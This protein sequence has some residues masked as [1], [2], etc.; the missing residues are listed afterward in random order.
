ME[1]QSR[2]DNL[3]LDGVPET[4]NESFETCRNK[5]V[6]ILE[7]NMQ[8]QNAR[9][10]KFVRCHRLGPKRDFSK[11][12][13]T[14]IFKF[15]YF[16]D[17]EQV[18]SSKTKLKNSDYWL[19]EDFPAE[20]KKR[21]SVLYPVLKKAWQLHLKAS[22]SVDKLII[23]GRT[24]TVDNLSS[25]PQE[26]DPAHIATRKVGNITCFFSSSS[27][28]SNFHNTTIKDADGKKFHTSE[29]FYQYHKAIHFNDEESAYKILLAD[30]PLECY[31]L[32]RTIKNFNKDVWHNGQAKQVMHK[33]VSAKFQ[34]NQKLCDFLLQTND[35][36]LVEANPRDRDWGVGLSVH[37]KDIGNETMWRG[38]NWLGEILMKVRGELKESQ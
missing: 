20:I 30:T 18:W 24:Y 16:Q 6:K 8:I 12:P 13:R 5:I 2:R 26:L 37:S 19:S 38:T 11:K 29:Q 23:S 15:H 31:K 14:L 22:L 35:S 32:G 34:Q 33:A 10:I 17:R 21:R 1:A 9:D 28:L 4:E 3:L 25:L 36:K 7:E 27:P